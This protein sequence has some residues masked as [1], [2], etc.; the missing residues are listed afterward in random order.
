MLKKLLKIGSLT[1]ILIG[2]IGTASAWE[3]PAYRDCVEAMGNDRSGKPIRTVVHSTGV[4]A[5]KFSRD[6]RTWYFQYYKSCNNGR[7]VAFYEGV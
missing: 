4:F 3:F 7:Y 5:N 2:G 1:A 6:G